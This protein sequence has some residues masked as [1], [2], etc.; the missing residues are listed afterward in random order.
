VIHVFE[1]GN[2]GF[3]IVLQICLWRMS[4]Y[5]DDTRWRKGRIPGL[6]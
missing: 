5:S 4:G 3:I 6:D 2:V 1:H